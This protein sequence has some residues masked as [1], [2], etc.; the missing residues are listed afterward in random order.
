M[1]CVGLIS[2]A[3]LCPRLVQK[4]MKLLP[5]PSD[6]PLGSTLARRVAQLRDFRNMTVRDLAK[7]SRFSVT[8]IDDIEQGLETWL[9]STDR[10]IL[11]KALNIEPSLLQEVERRAKLSHDNYD[12]L[13]VA[14]HQQHLA[15][16]IL[17]GARDLECPNCGGTLKCSVQ[18]GFDLEEKPIRFP[19]AFCLKCPFILK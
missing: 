15:D 13:L 11:A 18:E 12:A 2:I 10:Q 17:G 4:Q 1:I 7:A 3:A 16:A 9:S 8:R 14:A 6:F 19:K 5:L